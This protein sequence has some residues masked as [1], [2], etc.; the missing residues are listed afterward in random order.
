MPTLRVPTRLPDTLNLPPLLIQVNATKSENR[1]AHN[2]HLDAVVEI[3][4]DSWVFD[5]GAIYKSLSTPKAISMAL[6]QV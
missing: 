4:W 6:N 2:S 1:R 3:A 5:F